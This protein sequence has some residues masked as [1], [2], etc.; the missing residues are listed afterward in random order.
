MA[1]FDRGKC[2][3][4]SDVK[5]QIVPDFIRKIIELPIGKLVNKDSN[6]VVNKTLEPRTTTMILC[7][8]E[9]NPIITVKSQRSELRSQ[10]NPVRTKC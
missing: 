8:S 2:R 4:K 3:G 7:S 5:G 6:C 1:T 9:H 10:R